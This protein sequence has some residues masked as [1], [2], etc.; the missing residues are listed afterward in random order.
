M[1]ASRRWPA[2][3]RVAVWSLG[4]LVAALVGWLAAS[5]G[6]DGAAE[7]PASL[8][9]RVDDEHEQRHD[10]ATTAHGH[11]DRRPSTGITTTTGTGRPPLSCSAR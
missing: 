5:R 8:P 9:C 6:S 4:L 7:R 10:D 11:D 2:S 1:A 3:A